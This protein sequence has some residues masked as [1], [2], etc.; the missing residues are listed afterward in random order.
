MC[1]SLLIGKRAVMARS[2][3]L[4]LRAVF[5]DFLPAA[6]LADWAFPFAADFAW[7]GLPLEK[8]VSQPLEN[9]SLDPV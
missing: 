4:L 7:E 8:I 6:F 1:A 2:N 5:P 3:H 9:F